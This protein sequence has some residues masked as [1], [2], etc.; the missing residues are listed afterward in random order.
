MPSNKFSK[1]RLLMIRPKVC[2]SEVRIFNEPPTATVEIVPLEADPFT[3][4]VVTWTPI[5]PGYTGSPDVT[6]SVSVD[7]GTVHYTN[8]IPNNVPTDGSWDPE[9]FSGTCTMVSTFLWDDGLSVEITSFPI[10]F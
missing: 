7:L 9:G 8:P 5:R 3:I 10:S 6:L 1:R 2:K 4:R